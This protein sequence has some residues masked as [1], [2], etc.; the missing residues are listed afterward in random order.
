MYQTKWKQNVAKGFQCASS[1]HQHLYGQS[2]GITSICHR[3]QTLQSIKLLQIIFITGLNS[4]SVFAQKPFNINVLTVM[5]F[6][7]FSK[8]NKCKYILE[9]YKYIISKYVCRHHFTGNRTMERIQRFTRCSAKR[10]SISN[11]RL[12][13][14]K[15]QQ[16]LQR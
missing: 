7:D 9:Q 1:G 6:L 2:Y 12:G 15:F 11:I 14:L 5:L 16:N 8:P 10:V 13:Y 4:T 3:S